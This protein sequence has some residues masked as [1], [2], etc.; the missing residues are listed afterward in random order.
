MFTIEQ[1]ESILRKFLEIPEIYQVLRTNTILLTGSL[2]M[3]R[4]VCCANDTR[5]IGD[6][7]VV[8]KQRT[9]NLLS[10]C[11]GFNAIKP[12]WG[13]RG[14]QFRLDGMPIEVFDHWP[15]VN[16]RLFREASHTDNTHV[17][18]AN[19]GHILYYKFR[20]VLTCTNLSTMRV[21]ADCLKHLSDCALIVNTNPSLLCMLTSHEQRWLIDRANEN[22]YEISIENA[23]V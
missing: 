20:M 4:H 13:G 17:L 3:M 16:S 6:I 9:F 8:V 19:L 21:D 11:N 14:L 15:F 5:I 18:V 7:D 22:G 1:S 10:A 12:E 2:G 23:G